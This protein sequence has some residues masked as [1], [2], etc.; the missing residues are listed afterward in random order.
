MYTAIVLDEESVEGRNSGKS[1]LTCHEGI[2]RII[3]TNFRIIERE[4]ECVCVCERERERERER[5]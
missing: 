5:R 2:G 3:V 4:R 1:P